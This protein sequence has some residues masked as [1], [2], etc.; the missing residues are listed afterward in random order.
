[1]VRRYRDGNFGLAFA[2][3]V[4]DIRTNPLDDEKGIVEI[5]ICE[6]DSVKG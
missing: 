1:M 6:V 3:V 2:E 5:E 4:A